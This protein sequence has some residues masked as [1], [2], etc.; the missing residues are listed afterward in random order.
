[1]PLTRD[2]VVGYDASKMTFR[3]TMLNNGG[4][5]ECEISSAALDEL[6][7]GRGTALAAR[8]ALFLGQRPEIE[9][10][11]SNIF[12]DDTIVRSAVVRIF[13]KHIRR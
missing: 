5:V 13:A 1:M 8:E 6:A 3:F 9:R 10:I 4:K 7:G 2:T 11:A 12:D